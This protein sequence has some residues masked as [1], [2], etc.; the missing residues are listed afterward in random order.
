MASDERIAK[1][2]TAPAIAPPIPPPA[3][4][5]APCGLCWGQRRTWV[6]TTLGLAPEDCSGCEGTGVRLT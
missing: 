2:F 1:W 5:W 4:V 6:P 3:G